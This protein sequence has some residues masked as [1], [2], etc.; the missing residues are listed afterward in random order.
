MAF[1]FTTALEDSGLS[2][3]GMAGCN[4][5]P[6]MLVPHGACAIFEMPCFLQFKTYLVLKYYLP[7]SYP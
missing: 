2:K 3:N 5:L 1:I 4:A 6:V 7:L